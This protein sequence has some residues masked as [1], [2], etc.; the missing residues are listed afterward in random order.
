MLTQMLFQASTLFFINCVLALF[1]RIARQG[2]GRASTAVGGSSASA[3]SR[4]PS[5]VG[6]RKAHRGP[7]AKK[8]RWERKHV[9]QSRLISHSTPWA[10]QPRK[11]VAV[12]LLVTS[13]PRSRSVTWGP[14]I[15]NAV[16]VRSHRGPT[17]GGQP[18]V[19][20]P[21]HVLAPCL[22]NR[23]TPSSNRHLPSHLPYRSAGAKI[24]PGSPLEEASLVSHIHGL[25]PRASALEEAAQLGELLVLLGGGGGGGGGGG[26]DRGQGGEGAARE[27]QRAV[28]DWQAA[29]QVRG[30]R[31]VRFADS[32]P[33][34]CPTT[35]RR[36][37]HDDTCCIRRCVTR[38]Y[39]T[40]AWAPWH[41]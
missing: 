28:A 40:P 39:A 4:A 21:P 9:L 38:C 26:A 19:P 37:A 15:R 11:T 30:A 35:P 8:A 20:Y 2:D 22:V 41:S 18:G 6:G 13:P 25:A 33:T 12:L 16:Q 23:N 31:G 36:T 1:P 10:H 27:L 7:G 3:T 34:L 14:Y 32:V 17:A 29:Y 5:T 24:R